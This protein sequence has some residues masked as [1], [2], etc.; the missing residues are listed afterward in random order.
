MYVKGT[1]EKLILDNLTF[2]PQQS[3]AIVAFAIQEKYAKV[4]VI[5]SV[6]YIS[7][8]IIVIWRAMI[9]MFLS[10]K[11]GTVLLF[12]H[13]LYFCPETLTFNNR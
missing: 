6:L 13:H 5:C 4:H 1:F 2:D 7:T 8:T 12:L 11:N 9:K 3:C 10:Y